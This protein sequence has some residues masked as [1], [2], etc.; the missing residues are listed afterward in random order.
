MKYID[1]ERIV[2]KSWCNDPEENALAQ[3]RNLANLPFAFR[4]VC[5]MPDTHEGYGMP[6]GGV[7]ATQGAVIPNAVGVDIGCGMLAVRTSLEEF[8][9]SA[10]KRIVGIM[11]RTIP[12]G[13]D[14][15][16][17]AQDEYLMPPLDDPALYPEVSRQYR[18][19]CK[20]IGTLG[21]GNHFIEVQKGSDGHI[22]FMIHSGSRNIGLKVASRH[23]RIAVD[24][25]ERWHVAVPKK[26]ELA[27]LPVESEEASEYLR[28]MRYC[29]EFALA[30][31][32]L[33]ASRVRDA[34][35]DEFPEVTFGEAINIHHNY[36]S[37]ENHF[38]QIVL[39]HR[40][41]ATSAREGEMGIIP[42]SQG[43]ASYIV[44]G[45]GNPDS[46][47][48]CSHGA[49]RRMGRQAAVRNLDL[50]AEKKALEEKGILHA[51]RGKK[52]LEEAAGAYKDIDVVME[53]QRDL[54]D[55]IVRLEPLAVIKG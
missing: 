21:G 42:G 5:L 47:M 9:L 13:F 6:I 25:N 36:A 2:I 8:D 50:E 24:L 18:S 11:R 32:Q 48:S 12:V 28:E 1:T 15:H 29:L 55:I 23:N 34:F 45:K 51:L 22:W 17:E 33:M 49:G 20:Q 16:K 52:D 41:G 43:T 40:K 30:N 38:G 3:A 10:L 37:M 31:R 53:E 54:V 46:F 44:R 27:F 4:Q 35:R 14:H 39:V 7:I 26:W 19:A